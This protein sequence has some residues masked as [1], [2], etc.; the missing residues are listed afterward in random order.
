M[1]RIELRLD[2]RGVRV[3]GLSAYMGSVLDPA[4]F[5]STLKTWR[6]VAAVFARFGGDVAALFSVSAPRISH[7]PRAVPDRFTR[8]LLA[9]CKI[10]N[11]PHER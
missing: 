10:K 5:R 7:I 11:W 9:R 1:G 3:H 8:R 6:D 4:S 2:N